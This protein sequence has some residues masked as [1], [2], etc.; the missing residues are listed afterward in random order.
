MD[1]YAFDRIFEEVP[2]EGCIPKEENVA[3]RFVLGKNDERGQALVLPLFRPP[4]LLSSEA[5]AGTHGRPC[6]A[7]LPVGTL[8]WRR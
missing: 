1:E 6:A 3:R 5:A 4:V 8:C 2:P 7:A